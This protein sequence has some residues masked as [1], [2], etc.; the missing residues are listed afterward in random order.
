MKKIITFTAAAIFSVAGFA[1]TL[2]AH[3]DD[4]E[5]VYDRVEQQ[6]I[7]QQRIERAV[8]EQRVAQPSADR[9]VY[10]ERQFRRGGNDRPLFQRSQ[11]GLGRLQREVDHLNRMMD[12]VRGKMRAYGAGPRIRR[13]YDHLRDEA[14]RLNNQFRRGEQYYDRRRVRAQI[15]HMHEELH[16]IE[17]NLHFR[18]QDMYRWR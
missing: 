17:Q 14:Y 1:P 10:E 16:E 9:Q 2:S 8:Y 4:D 13:Q 5:N 7:E 11:D 15:E 12:H 3:E 6:P 18:A